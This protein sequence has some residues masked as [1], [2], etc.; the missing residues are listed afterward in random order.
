[1]ERHFCA[2]GKPP[3]RDRAP[4]CSSWSKTQAAPRPRAAES[5]RPLSTE[6]CG[7]CR[8][9]KFGT[10]TRWVRSRV[11]TGSVACSGLP[12][13][14]R[15]GAAWSGTR[16]VRRRGCLIVTRSAP[17]C[18]RRPSKHLVEVF[19]CVSGR[20][21]GEP[22]V[23]SVVLGMRVGS[24]FGGHGESGTRTPSEETA[25]RRTMHANRRPLL[26]DAV[27]SPGRVLPSGTTACT[28][29]RRNQ[30]A[31]TATERSRR[32]RFA[33]RVD[34]GGV[35]GREIELLQHREVV[36]NGPVF[37]RLRRRMSVRP[38]TRAP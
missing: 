18:I 28:G 24:G 10:D 12:A 25:H 35:V 3:R 19:R 8:A 16:R 6:S 13:H 34:E 17:D 2:V 32:A 15:A 27:R 31:P 29:L 33:E 38:A 20:G 7:Q 30:R 21:G 9:C 11:P 22:D 5:A 37:H 4:A 14:R 23:V 26:R 1:M 36:A